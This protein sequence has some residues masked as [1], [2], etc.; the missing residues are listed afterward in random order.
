[1]REQILQY[2]LAPA[3]RRGEVAADIERLEAEIVADFDV[4]RS[5]QGLT[6]N[7]V[8]LID[9]TEG[10]IALWY[11]ARDGGPMAKTDAGDLTG[12]AN[13]ALYG[14]GGEAFLTAFGAI[15]EF[16]QETS[17]TAGAAHEGA[18]STV[19]TARTL[20][21]I[22][23]ALMSAIAVAVGY[24]LARGITGGVNT[25]ANALKEIATGDLTKK[26]EI[27]TSDEIGEM[28]ESYAQVRAYLQEMA[29]AAR[30]LAGG[31]LSADVTARSENDA[32]GN[33]FTEMI[34]VLK[35]RA[36]VA[37]TIADGDLTVNPT[38]ASAKDT[39]GTALVRMVANLRDLIG[40]VSSTAN[41]VN[42]SS[43][44]MATIAEQAGQATQAIATTVGRQRFRDTFGP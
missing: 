14:I 2:P 11:K 36:S 34:A 25:I 17:V 32:L 13:A 12:A 33:S 1:M 43:D 29:T 24:W 40:R 18:L 26:V 9:E 23:I 16:A 28:A 3:E 44:E 39:L 19:S 5:Q 7:Q 30:L 6:E 41:N 31:D 20:T 8:Q 37:E 38:A 27:N 42:S 22:L 10:A 35:E 15:G 4:L 21:I